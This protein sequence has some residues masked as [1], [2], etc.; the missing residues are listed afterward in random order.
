MFPWL[1]LRHMGFRARDTSRTYHILRALFVAGLGLSVVVYFIPWYTPAGDVLK[2]WLATGGVER[3]L[4]SFDLCRLLLSTG[5]VPRAAFYM[6]LEAIEIALLLLAVVRP[7]RWVF[8]AGVCEQLYTLS[9]FLLPSAAKEFPQ[10]LFLV[11]LYYASWA[12]CFT[13]IFVRPPPKRMMA[14]P[15]PEPRTRT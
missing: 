2:A 10:P 14:R 13:G 6:V 1:I 5:N 7:R 9:A 3:R 15:V 8:I 4:S 11:L 12:M